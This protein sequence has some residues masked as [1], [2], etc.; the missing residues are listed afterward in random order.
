[1]F[2]SVSIDALLDPIFNLPFQGLLTLT[3]EPMVAFFGGMVILA[4]C[5]SVLGEYCMAGAYMLNYKH[6]NR[7]TKDMVDHH[8]LSIDAIKCQDKKS[9]TACNK[10]ANDAFGLN[11]FSGIALFASSVWPAFLAM[12]WLQYR[13]G[14]VLIE[15]PFYI[16]GSGDSTVGYAFFFI[17]IYILSRIAFAKVK[18][19]IPFFARMKEFV[20]KNE[21]KDE[22]RSWTELIDE[23]NP[24]QRAPRAQG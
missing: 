21:F 19:V 15:M 2:D 9:Y 5:L 13:F 11:F 14:S 24:I 16:P 12:S 22:M 18:H 1:M 17:P 3:G 6:F 20:R 4:F 10:L 8:N 7:V 23:K